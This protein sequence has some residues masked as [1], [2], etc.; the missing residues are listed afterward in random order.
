MKS[1]ISSFSKRI[2]AVAK[3]VLATVFFA[4]FSISASASIEGTWK[5]EPVAGAL[6]VGPGLGDIGWWSNSAD[7][8]EGRA[9]LFDDTY[10]FGPGD[11]FSQSMGDAT[12]LE[13]WQGVAEGCGAPIAPHDG[14]NPATYVY[15]AAAGTLTVSGDGAHIGLAK[16]HNTGEDG[17]SGGSITYDVTTLA[18]GKMTLDINFGPGYWR[19]KLVKDTYVAPDDVSVTFQVNMADVEEVSADGVYLAGGAFGQDGYL[20]TDNGDGIWSVTLPLA[21]NNRYQYKFR[22]QPSYGTWNGFEEQDGLIAGGCGIGDYNDRFVDV[23]DADITLPVVRYGSCDNEAPPVLVTYSATFS[24]DMN[25]VD[26]GG[27]TPTINGT[28]NGWCG[29]CNELTDE[30]GDGIWT[31][32]ID[33]QAGTYEY[34]FTVGNWVLQE[35][36]PGECSLDPEAA[37]INRAVTIT[38]AGITAPVTPYNGCADTSLGVTGDWRIAPEEAAIGVGAAKGDIGWWSNSAAASYT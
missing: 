20:M 31:T 37:N 30:D 32:T 22:N 18:D 29:S 27:E 38:D 21:P 34:K 23:A 4:S 16:V 28:F 7:D 33:L 19:F 11:S 35:D 13:G 6:G 3:I 15:D 10:T 14:S 24:V 2:G 5:L 8:V 17:N 9:C 36:V 25:G 1:F 12:W 26:L